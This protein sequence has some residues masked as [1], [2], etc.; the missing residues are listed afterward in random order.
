MRDRVT[1]RVRCRACG[2]ISAIPGRR[3]RR[4]AGR[5]LPGLQRV[6][7]LKAQSELEQR[8]MDELYPGDSGE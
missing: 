2:G 7:R 4:A 5:L 8:I 3:W 6:N 1:W